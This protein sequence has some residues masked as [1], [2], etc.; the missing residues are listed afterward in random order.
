[1]ATM[2]VNYGNFES[3][4]SRLDAKNKQL[5]ETLKEIESKINGL[6]GEWE[7]NSGVSIREAISGMEPKFNS[8][9][10]V[11]NNYVKFLKNA[12]AEWKSTEATNDQNANQFM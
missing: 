7:S 4:A 6:A 3:W 8:Y 10:E 9:Y 11:V 5:D 1:M 2:Y 12:A